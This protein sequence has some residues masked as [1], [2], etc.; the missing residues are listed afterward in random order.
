MACMVIV[1]VAGLLPVWIFGQ[2]QTVGYVLEVA[3]AWTI[4]GKPVSKGQ[5][6]RGGSLLSSAQKADGDRIVVSDTNGGLLLLAECKNNQCRKCRKTGDCDQI[7]VALP[8]DPKPV[9][10]NETSAAMVIR[11]I[12]EMIWAKPEKYSFA[13]VRG[14]SLTD[15]VLRLGPNGCDLGAAL[16]DI[17]RGAYGVQFKSIPVEGKPTPAFTSETVN[18]NWVPSTEGRLAVP[19]LRPGLYQM[20]LTQ[21]ESPA[22]SAALTAWVLVAETDFPKVSADFKSAEATVASWGDD[23]SPEIAQEYIRAT[24]EYLAS[25]LPTGR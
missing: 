2:Q 1:L 9:R 21:R 18:L 17:E 13:R 20:T 12:S 4:E 22:P 11:V 6:I 16:S 25:K 5:G 10:E 19:G 8:L 3:G 15:S 7:I 23:V 24:L 14:D